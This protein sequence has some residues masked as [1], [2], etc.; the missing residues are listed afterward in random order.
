MKEENSLRSEHYGWADWV[1][2]S[3]VSTECFLLVFLVLE[4]STLFI[5]C[6]VGITLL[7]YST[8]VSI[9]CQ[10]CIGL[11]ILVLPQ[12][13]KSS[14]WNSFLL[15]FFCLNSMYRYFTNID[16]NLNFVSFFEFFSVYLSECNELNLP[17]PLSNVSERNTPVNKRDRPSTRSPKNMNCGTEIACSRFW[18]SF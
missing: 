9:W 4:P 18:K 13:I 1:G 8:V 11:T 12:A 5:V 6:N 10:N 14:S 17:R 16:R 3:H 7:Y 15:H 2:N